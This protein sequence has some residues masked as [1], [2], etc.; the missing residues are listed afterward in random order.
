VSL[1]ELIAQMTNQP[2]TLTS[3]LIAEPNRMYGD[4]LRKGFASTRSRFQVMGCVSSA[5]EVLVALAKCTPQVTL[6]SSDLQEGPS[7]GIH[8]L[9]E[10]RRVYPETRLL[11]LMGTPERELVAEAFRLGAV[12][13]FNR[14]NPFA[15][16]CKAVE[17]VARGQIWANTEELHYVLSA[18]AKSPKQPRLDPTVEGRITKR[19]A[20]VVRLAMEGLS[21]REIAQRLS[22]TE[23][24]VKNYLFRVFEK[25]GV[26]NRVELVLSC[27]RQEEEEREST[28]PELAMTKT[29]A[30]KDLSHIGQR[31]RP[32]LRVPLTA[33]S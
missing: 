8:I 26:S 22:L 31:T 16:L 30:V 10:V 3:V 11:V 5:A 19:E 2:R 18:F 14:N 27:L 25:L 15:L 20:A 24:T 28:R 17:V 9:P 29:A 13:V 12:G 33:V 6:I 23:H 4:L 7:S 21:N 32:S 1:N